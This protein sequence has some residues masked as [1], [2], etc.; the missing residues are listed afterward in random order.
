[1]RVD[2]ADHRDD[3]RGKEDEESPEDGRVN[4]TRHH[5]LEELALPEDIGRLH[6]DARGDVLEAL[7]RFARAEQPNEECRPAR[8][9]RDG[10]DDRQAQGA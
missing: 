5:S 8:E 1:M 4:E 7:R 3:D 6:L 10:D 9:Q 2:R